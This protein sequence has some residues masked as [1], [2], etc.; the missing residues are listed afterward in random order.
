M[1][2]RI[3]FNRI[4]EIS[5]AKLKISLQYPAETTVLLESF[6]TQFDEFKKDLQPEYY[7]YVVLTNKLLLD[8]LDYSKFKPGVDIN[9]VFNMLIYISEGVSKKVTELYGSDY[10]LI[11]E[12]R[13]SIQEEYNKYLDI[14]KE[15][16]YIN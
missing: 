2:P 14:I 9:V 12:N 13:D 1:Y 16:V 3:F 11:L 4:S 7:K 15:S 6:G 10:K 5:T 8:G